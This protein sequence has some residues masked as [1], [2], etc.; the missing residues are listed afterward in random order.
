MNF[1]LIGAGVIARSHAEAIRKLDNADEV[2]LIVADTNPQVLRDFQALYPEAE[3]FLDAQEM[4]AGEAQDDDIVVI[5]APP[6]THFSLSKMALESGRHVLCEK[7]L[8]MNEEE[9]DELLEIARR[10]NRQLGCCSVRFIGLPK[11]DE[12]KRLL[13]T[14]Q[15]GDIYKVTFIHRGQ[16]GRPGV[17]YQPESKWFLDR[18]K[19]GGGIV[20]D[21]GP[22]DFTVINDILKPTSV[23]VTAAWTSK[24]QTEVDPVD[25]VYDVEGHVGAMLKYHAEGKSIWVHYER[26]HCTHGKPYHLV[27]IEGTKGAV[28]WSPY[29]ESD[30]VIF[31]TDKN[32]EV[33]TEEVELANTNAIDYMDHPIHYFYRKVKG[34]PSP[35]LT[36]EQAIFNF[37]CLQ[38]LYK[39][40]ETGAGAVVEEVVSA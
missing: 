15:L 24:P 23:E 7:P 40:A 25:T 39:A 30:K 27:E 14:N 8:V 34:E 13:E 18:S 20:M 17:E 29:F 21:W 5:C 9:A 6:F 4:L 10:N 16:R 2:T 11:L 33:V 12:I 37:K 26:A 31:R 28:E 35:A 38:A 19:S 32:G 36:N 3:T 22:Y 1:Y